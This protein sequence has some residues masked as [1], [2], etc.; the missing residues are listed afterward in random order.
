MARGP[1]RPAQRVVLPNGLYLLLYED[2]GSMKIG[3]YDRKLVVT[4]LMT[5]AGGTQLFFRAE[6]QKSNPKS[7][8]PRGDDLVP[9]RRSVIAAIQDIKG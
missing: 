7:V 2:D 4:E 8:T 1:Q 9:V 6:P 3:G 5:R